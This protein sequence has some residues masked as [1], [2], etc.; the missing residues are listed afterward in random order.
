MQAITPVPPGC[1]EIP[2]VIITLPEG[3]W[4]RA[5]GTVTDQWTERGVWATAE[6][7]AEFLNIVFQNP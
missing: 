7:A 3:R 2:G 6:D 5:D 4:F 1:Q